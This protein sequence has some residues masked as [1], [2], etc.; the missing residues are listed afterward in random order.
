MRLFL[1][2]EEH[3]LLKRNWKAAFY[4]WHDIFSMFLH[5][6]KRTIIILILKCVR[7]KSNEYFGI[8]KHYQSKNKNNNNCNKVILYIKWV[9][10]IIHMQIQF[11]QN[12]PHVS[13]LIWQFSLTSPFLVLC[14]QDWTGIQRH[15]GWPHGADEWSSLPLPQQALT[16]HRKK[17]NHLIL[18]F[19]R[20]HMALVLPFTHSDKAFFNILLSL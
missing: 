8:G 9:R 17:I 20:I 5:K 4:C 2:Y 16:C 11:S 3:A 14:L 12:R 15:E 1:D 18:P 13:T 7:H 6:G 10:K 19:Y